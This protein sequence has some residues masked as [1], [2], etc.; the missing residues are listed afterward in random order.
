M[1]EQGTV[2]VSPPDPDHIVKAL[3]DMPQRHHDIYTFWSLEQ[4]YPGGLLRYHAGQVAMLHL[5]NRLV[6][7][8]FTVHALICDS[9]ARSL[10]VD[11]DTSQESDANITSNFIAALSDRSIIVG[12]MSDYIK[13][14]P[15]KGA[16]NAGIDPDLVVQGALKF[17]NAVQ[18]VRPSEGVLNELE[19]YRTFAADLSISDPVRV[20]IAKLRDV[21]PCPSVSDAEL[22]AAL[23]ASWRRPKWFDA[24]WL[25][26]MA[27]WLASIDGTSGRK[28]VI[29]EANRSA[30]SWLTHQCFLK[31]GIVSEQSSP[32]VTWPSM[33]FVEPLLAMDGKSAMELS[34]PRTALFVAAPEKKIQSM[35]ER[36]PSEVR[37]SFSRWFSG[38]ISSYGNFDSSFEPIERVVLKAREEVCRLELSKPSITSAEPTRTRESGEAPNIALCLSGGGFRATFFHL[39]TISLLRQCSLLPRVRAVYSVSGGSILAANLALNWEKYLSPDEGQFKLASAPLIA[40]TKANPRGKL[41]W[42]TGFGMLSVVG[43]F[44]LKRLYTKTA[45]IQGE[46]KDLPAEPS[47]HILATS[48]KSGNLISFSK[49]GVRLGGAPIGGKHLPLAQAVTASSAF[50][51]LLSPVVLTA[52]QLLVRE[53]ELGAHIERLTDGGVYDNLGLVS[54]LDEIRTGRDEHACETVLASD[55]SAPFLQTQKDTYSYIVGRTART[56]DILMKRVADLESQRVAM[57]A[58]T[59]LEHLSPHLVRINIENKVEQSKVAEQVDASNYKVQDEAIQSY[60]ATIRTDLNTFSEVEIGALLRHGYE[61]ALLQLA[62]HGLLPKDFKP[63]DPCAAL[64]LNFKDDVLSIRKKLA[65]ASVR[66]YAGSWLLAMLIISGVLIL[67]N[68]G[69][70]KAILSQYFSIF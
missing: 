63:Q 50:P 24:F 49:G 56:T 6:E 31:L 28:R 38:N 32:T 45:K 4:A 53:E 64:G 10:L 33:C 34:K 47:F 17:R 68:R 1:I 7:R 25:G 12:K 26:E 8:G 14:L 57:D 15:P 16:S 48:I 37:Q 70:I 11:R 44:L 22:L 46:L 60:V 40:L 36:A 69:A 67:C 66:S 5:M 61:T 3:G 43:P 29:L 51:P 27:A 18:T 55:A 52:K 58:G 42:Y 19:K 30:Y 35:L 23:Y 9:Q 54:L 41:L 59:H 2:F 13:R 21:M 20:Y 62:S 65:A 39:G